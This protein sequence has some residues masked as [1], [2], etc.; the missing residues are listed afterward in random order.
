MK[1]S[2]APSLDKR[3]AADL[4]VLP[5]WEGPA[6]AAELGKLKGLV[7]TSLSS[8]DFK[9]KN[10]ECLLLYPEGEREGRFLL[11]G[12]GK[13]EKA[14]PE[15]LRRAYSCAAA[16][17]RGKKAKTVNV[18]FPRSRTLSREDL[19]RGVW[20]GLLL[21]NYGF[22]H[23]KG[24]SLKE[25]LP[26]IEKIC[27][28]GV[29]RKEEPLLEKL[30]TIAGGVYLA[31]EL[32]NGNADDVTPRMLAD[33]ALSLAKSNAKL[34][35]AIYDKKWLEQQKMGLILAVN[36]A[37]SNDPFLIQMSY[38]GNPRSKEH[39][40]LVGKGVT[41]DT[42]GLS[43]KPTDGM[44]T[45][46]CDMAA[47]AA[48]MGAIYVA[49]ALGLKVNVTALAPVVENCIGSRSYK[50]GDVYRG[51]SGKTVEIGNTDAEGRLILADA[52]SYAVQNLKPTSL[53]DLATLTG[54]IV[55]ALGEEIS[56]LYTN[57]ET[58][59]GDLTAASEKTAELLWRMPLHSE[60]RDALK[61]DIAD[62]VSVGGRDAGSMK[63]ALFLQEFV[64]DASW[65]HLD[66]AGPAFLTKPKYYNPT[67]ATGYGVR[68]LVEFLERRE[69]K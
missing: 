18:V 47:A 51:Y 60:Y 27:W 50:P 29:E 7:Q 19:L 24:D 9:G 65:A 67:K 30:R 34:K 44:L 31:R 43:L 35:T 8:G 32:V 64:G 15:T 41:Y 59:A 42:G 61:S 58:L 5:F 12:L 37:S 17:A 66:I 52:L 62:L 45:M 39:I 2:Y 26:L 48:A 23:L 38:K 22:N 40:V 57:D 11:L 10:G 49:A 21:A 16:A 20:E 53:I 36:R 55:I 54:A 6:E 3:D 4:A 33:T 69:A 46:K 14:T 56:G 25:A 63:A 68:L 1:H 13:G 28:I